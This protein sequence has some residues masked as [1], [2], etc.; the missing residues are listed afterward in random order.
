MTTPTV[1]YAY[2]TSE[3][4]TNV[5]TQFEYA[6]HMGAT[7]KQAV[8]ISAQAGFDLTIKQWNNKRTGSTAFASACAVLVM[9]GK[10]IPEQAKGNCNE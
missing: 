9:A 1:N 3:Q 8:A 4:R 6:L 10:L 7:W 5:I 2:I